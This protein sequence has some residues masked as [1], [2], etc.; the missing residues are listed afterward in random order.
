MIQR[1]SRAEM[2]KCWNDQHRFQAWL[3]VELAVCQYYTQEGLITSNEYLKLRA[4]SKFSVDRISELEAETRH[5]VVAFTRCVS[6]S[7]G[8]ES[9]W[10]HYG[11]TSTDVVDTAYGLVFKSV[12]DIIRKD[13]K[14]ISK[15]LNEMAL[16]YRSTPCIG[17]THGVHADITCFGL[18]FALC[19]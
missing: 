1:Y 12:N 15:T 4:D 11:M 14:E 2:T 7:L 17:R 10:I 8:A 18:K 6:E 13:L 9:R 16:R 5:D 3:E 19:V